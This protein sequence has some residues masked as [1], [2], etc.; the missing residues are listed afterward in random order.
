[1]RKC[2]SGS[3]LNSGCEAVIQAPALPSPLQ[4]HIH[5]LRQIWLGLT[6]RNGSGDTGVSAAMHAAAPVFTN[7]GF[8]Q[9]FGDIWFSGIMSLL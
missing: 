5:H 4:R 6:V 9:T 3:N 1:M 7:N 8:C 2:L